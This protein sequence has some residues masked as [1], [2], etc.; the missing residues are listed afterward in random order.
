MLRVSAGKSLPSCLR[1]DIPL[2]TR[3]S[4]AP[5]HALSHSLHSHSLLA[6]SCSHL[7]EG[8]LSLSVHALSRLA[9]L[10]PHSCTCRRLHQPAERAGGT[11]ALAAP[12]IRAAPRRR[13]SQARRHTSPLRM[14]TTP[15]LSLSLPPSLSPFLPPFPAP[16]LLSLRRTCQA[17]CHVSSGCSRNGAVHPRQHKVHA[18]F[19]AHGSCGREVSSAHA[20]THAHI[21]THTHTH[22]HTRTHA[23]TR[24]SF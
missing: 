5:A 17:R 14:P 4:L 2:Q 1:V 21:H 15:S 22:T 24:K 16:P 10:S 18:R 20:R 11:A 3:I 13:T 6:F 23:C 19:T 7:R 8:P 12:A 9:P